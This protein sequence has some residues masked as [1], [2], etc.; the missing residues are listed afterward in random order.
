MATLFS[1]SSSLHSIRLSSTTIPSA[2]FSSPSLAFC[3]F[4]RLPLISPLKAHPI[5]NRRLRVSKAVEEETQ[6]QQQQ[7]EQPSTTSE[8]SPVVVPISPS[9]TLTMFFQ[10]RNFSCNAHV[11]IF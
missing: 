3:T 5:K 2:S 9:D 10:V 7:E 8:Q 4:P 6:Q 11:K 1:S